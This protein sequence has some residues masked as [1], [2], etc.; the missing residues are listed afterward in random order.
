MNNF[1]KLV[2]VFISVATFKLG[3]LITLYFTIN[4]D[5]P[6]HYEIESR[7]LN[8]TEKECYTQSDIE[9]IVFGKVLN[10]DKKWTTNV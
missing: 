6:K 10:Y 3:V 8:Y 2:T 7:C 4:L 5:P 9:L 1:Q